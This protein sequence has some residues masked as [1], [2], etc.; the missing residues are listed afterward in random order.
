LSD[1]AAYPKRYCPACDQLVPGFGP[2][3]A[4]RA[5]ARCP[6]C[7]ALERHRFLAL[8]LDTL[9]PSF[10]PVQTVL[11]V[12][13]TPTVTRVVQ[14]IEPGTY[15]RIDLGAHRLVDV[16]ASVTQLPF[17]DESIHLAI[18]FHVLEHVPDDS[19]AMRELGRVLA[20]GGLA[21]VQVPWRPGV[22][23]EED[24]DAGAEERLRRFGQ[25]DH[26]RAYGSDF[27]ARLVE[28][29]LAVTRVNARAYFGSQACVWFGL[30]PKSNLWILRSTGTGSEPADIEPVSTRLTLA[31]DAL[32]GQVVAERAAADHARERV[33]RLRDRVDLLRQAN[34]RL[35]ETAGSAPRPIVVRAARRGRR[36]ARRALGR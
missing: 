31:M 16:R 28:Q 1:L 26:V 13:P 12:S 27:E 2:G 11:D 19:Q 25:R 17:A 34:A 7:G 3:P 15:V 24:L 14:R 36:M 4:G 9:R 23:T 21:I 22:P 32:V 29:G 33:S 6:E 5:N 20:P 10:G 30:V 8:L 35:R 18:C